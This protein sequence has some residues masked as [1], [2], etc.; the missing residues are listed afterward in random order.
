MKFSVIW[1]LDAND[2]LLDIV[3]FQR[4]KYGKK[5]ALE[6]YDSIHQKVV[7]TKSQP[8]IGR[9]VPELAVLGLTTIRELIQ[10][11][12]RI[13]Y[14]VNGDRIEILSVV[15]GRR[16]SEEVLYRKVLEGKLL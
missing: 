9:V 15:D 7:V 14:S 13:L 12:W 6:V 1:S 2:E 5:K 10:N 3:A 8:E 16:N 4:E 11:P